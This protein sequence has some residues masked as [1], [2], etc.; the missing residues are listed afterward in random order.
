MCANIFGR[1]LV[2]CHA[3]Q[4]SMLGAAMI[5][6]EQAGI[7]SGLEAYRPSTG[8]VITPDTGTSRQYETKFA[9]YL[10]AYQRSSG[11]IAR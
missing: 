9:R 3:E 5:C 4:S 10:E 6:S 7:L 2:S 8:T 11:E 1:P